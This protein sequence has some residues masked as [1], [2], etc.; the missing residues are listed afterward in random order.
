[1]QRFDYDALS[2]FSLVSY[3]IKVLGY[4]QYAF[5]LFRGDYPDVGAEP[6]FCAGGSADLP[7]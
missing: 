6:P 3:E 2:D 4:T 1:M 5:Y 7:T